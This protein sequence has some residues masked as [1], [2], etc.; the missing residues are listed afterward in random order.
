MPHS[1]ENTSRSRAARGGVF[2]LRQRFRLDCSRGLR[3]ERGNDV[4][5]RI[6]FCTPER[7][8][9]DFHDWIAGPG[10]FFPEC[11][12]STAR[13]LRSRRFSGQAGLTCT[14]LLRIPPNAVSPEPLLF[15]NG[16]PPE[17]AAAHTFLLTFSMPT[18]SSPTGLS[19]PPSHGPGK[20][21]SRHTRRKG[22]AGL[23]GSSTR[24]WRF[25]ACSPAEP[26]RRTPG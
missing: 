15:T 25:P 2:C 9:S 4:S 12:G 8:I 24:R 1:N 6:F 17:A 16:L 23:P 19:R 20:R 11:L 10:T 18:F 22:A 14:L 26:P 7:S 5:G 13:S 3:G 21:P